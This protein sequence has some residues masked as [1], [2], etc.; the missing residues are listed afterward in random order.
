MIIGILAIQGSVIEHKIAL[1][2]IGLKT[3]EI[4]LPHDLENISGIVLPGGESTVQSKLMQ[5]FDLFDQLKN[6][7]QS[8]LPAWGTCA[9]AILLAKEV[10]GKNPP[11]TLQVMDIQADR[12]AYGGQLESFETTIKFQSREKIPAVFIRAPKLKPLKKSV[13]ILAEFKQTPVMLQQKNI[14]ATSFHPELT[15]DLTIHRYFIS[16]CQLS[17]K[18]GTHS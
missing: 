3:K 1:E 7:V 10:L 9:G 15:D 18:L 2:K 14:L 4:R 17:N 12:N 8:G 6:R 16:L 5:E 13:Q 11:E